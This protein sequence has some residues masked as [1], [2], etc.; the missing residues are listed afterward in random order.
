M[1]HRQKFAQKVVIFSPFL[2]GLFYAKKGH[3]QKFAQNYV[4]FYFIFGKMF[5]PYELCLP[6]LAGY[7]F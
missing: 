3:R 6:F 7:L 5:F 1:L 4:H 2:G